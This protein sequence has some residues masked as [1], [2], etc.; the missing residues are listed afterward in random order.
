MDIDPI[1][2]VAEEIKGDITLRGAAQARRIHMLP[3]AERFKAAL[4]GGA[5]FVWRGRDVFVYACD[6]T[7]R[8][9]LTAIAFGPD[10]GGGPLETLTCDFWTEDAYRVI[11][12]ALDREPDPA[13]I[14]HA[15]ALL[16]P[17]A[18]MRNPKVAAPALA[19]IAGLERALR[20]WDAAAAH[21]AR[22]AELDPD[23][24][25]AALLAAQ[26]DHRPQTK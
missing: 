4:D 2:Q 14:R 7:L 21:A 18:G 23:D 22:A 9:T 1:A 6:L 3:V 20:D 24:P 19:Q 5:E 11:K 12:P 15:I 26:S 10:L 17:L 16:E 13:R 8:A 25:I